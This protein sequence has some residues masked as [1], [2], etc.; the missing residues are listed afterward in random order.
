MK[1]TT[2]ADLEKMT[3]QE[4]HQN[5]EDSIVWDLDLIPPERLDRLRA[6]FAD[7]IAQRDATTPS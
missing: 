7:R 5:F 1:I 4:R 2:V 3:P 6:Q